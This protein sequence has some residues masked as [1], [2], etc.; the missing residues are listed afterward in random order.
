MPERFWQLY[1]KLIRI[2]AKPRMYPNSISFSTVK[3]ANYC[4]R[5]SEL[6]L[7]ETEYAAGCTPVRPSWCPCE[8][9]ILDA[10][11]SVERRDPPHI[12]RRPEPHVVTTRRF[13]AVGPRSQQGVSVL[14]RNLGVPA[15]DQ[16]GR[17]SI[18]RIAE[19]TSIT[20]VNKSCL[21][22]SIIV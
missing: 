12:P 5:G 6:F 20:P 21:G 8:V 10:I 2:K 18:L 11:D 19:L 15:V 14:R 9:K 1:C 22:S 3:C 4:A 13:G 16:E 17:A 7:P